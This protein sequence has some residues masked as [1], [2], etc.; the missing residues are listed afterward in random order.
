MESE[1]VGQGTVVEIR[2]PTIERAHAQSDVCTEQKIAPK[3]ILVVDDN[4]DAAESLATVL[5]LD[6]HIVQT[7]YD[8]EET[9]LKLPAFAP[10]ALLLDLGLPEIDGLDLARRIRS[11]PKYARLRIVAVTGYSQ[12]EDKRRTR[13]SGFDEHLVKPVAYS[14]LARALQ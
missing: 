3:R 5:R 12:P 1:G 11:D 8:S 7:A 10:D 14:D 4:T 13:E 6:G 2:L 9:L